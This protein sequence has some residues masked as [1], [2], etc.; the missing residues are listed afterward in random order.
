MNLPSVIRVNEPPKGVLCVLEPLG[1]RHGSFRE[2]RVDVGVEGRVAAFASG[3][4]ERIRGTMGGVARGEGGRKR[5][6]VESEEEE[7]RE[8]RGEEGE[9]ESRVCVSLSIIVS[10][11][12]RALGR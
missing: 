2:S 6:N 1:S 4:E 3:L 11:F 5:E 9:D 12:E 8:E 7:R 10:S